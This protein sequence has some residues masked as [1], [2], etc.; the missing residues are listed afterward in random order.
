MISI[1]PNANYLGWRNLQSYDPSNCSALCNVTSTCQS[2]NMCTYPAP[3]PSLH[4]DL[5]VM[6]C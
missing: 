2:F 4:S 5:A 6:C 3:R 1:V